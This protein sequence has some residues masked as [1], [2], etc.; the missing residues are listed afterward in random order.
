LHPTI[1]PDDFEQQLANAYGALQQEMTVLLTQEG[2]QNHDN[3]D[4]K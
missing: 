4:S 3:N 1:D 2:E